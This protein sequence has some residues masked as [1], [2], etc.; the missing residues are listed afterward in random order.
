MK[1]PT[2]QLNDFQKCNNLGFEQTTFVDF[3]G[4]GGSKPKYK[5]LFHVELE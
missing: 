3:W 1:K 5:E 4:H 2:P